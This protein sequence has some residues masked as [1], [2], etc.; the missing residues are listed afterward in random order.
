V[1]TFADAYLAIAICFAVAFLMV[2]FMQKVAPP[3]AP[4][5]AGH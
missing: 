5:P 3:K 1:Q 2:P 4:S